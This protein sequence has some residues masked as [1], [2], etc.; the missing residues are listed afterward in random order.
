MRK[1]QKIIN[2]YEDRDI[3]SIKQVFSIGTEEDLDQCWSYLADESGG[4]YDV[5]TFLS[6]FYEFSNK[7]L[8]KEPQL[9]FELILE[10][11]ESYFY[12][13]IWNG[14]VAKKL[15][16]H[17][18]Y[19]A[20]HYLIKGERLSVRIDRKVSSVDKKSGIK[21]Q[22]IIESVTSTDHATK[23]IPV[24]S[25][26]EHEDLEDLLGLSDDMQEVMMV[27][28]KHGFADELFVKFRSCLSLFSLTL[29]NYYELRDIATT[30]TNLSALV[31]THQQ[32]FEILSEDELV[33]IEGFVLGVDRWL[34]TL[35]IKGGADLAFMD[36]SL[37]AD[38][39]MIEML[40]LPQE[41][42]VADDDDSLDDIFDF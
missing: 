34:N 31:N 11:S 36:D 13:T 16:E 9:F 30:I 3:S 39:N 35:F 22:Q 5:H 41:E 12:F 10:R 24:Y 21:E 15:S 33:L 25:F 40:I 2:L 32:R 27:A 38:L 17:L 18:T 28:K 8:S 42:R 26:L 19:E 1:K 23:D 29:R 6:I 7:A 4:S 14:D 20:T 37:Q